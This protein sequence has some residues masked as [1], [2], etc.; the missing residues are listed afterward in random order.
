MAEW[1]CIL[2]FI[3]HEPWLLSSEQTCSFESLTVLGFLQSVSWRFVTGCFWLKCTLGVVVDFSHSVFFLWPSMN[4][5]DIVEHKCSFFWTCRKRTLSKSFSLAILFGTLFL[6]RDGGPWSSRWRPPTESLAS[7]EHQ[8]LPAASQELV[9]GNGVP[10]PSDRHALCLG[11]E[12]G[13]RSHPEKSAGQLRLR[14]NNQL[15]E[16]KLKRSTLLLLNKSLFSSFQELNRRLRAPVKA[17]FSHLCEV[18]RPCLAGSE[19]QPDGEAQIS[20]TRQE[21]GDV[22]MKLKSQ[23]AGLPFYW[24]FHCSPAPVTVVR[25][26][27]YMWT[28]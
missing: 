24:E 28:C 19:G 9:W 2:Y 22:S 8:R 13:L 16:K 1:V 6:G 11:G 26:L 21:D 27:L 20:L 25:S 14:L 5:S 7:C 10:R 12:H 15:R 18:V 17:F 4:D 23:L 3:T